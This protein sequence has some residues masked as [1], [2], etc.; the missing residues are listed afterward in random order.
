MLQSEDNR[1]VEDVIIAECAKI[2]K[3]QNIITVLAIAKKI[4]ELKRN[5]PGRK[6]NVY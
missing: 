3:E 4:L 5:Y 6:R 2:G 1:T